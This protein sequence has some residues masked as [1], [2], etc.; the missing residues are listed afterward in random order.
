MKAHEIIRELRRPPTTAAVRW[1]LQTGGGTKDS[2]AAGQVVTY[3]D[4]RYVAER[5]NLVL[6]LGWTD[7]YE[8]LRNPQGEIVGCE[9]TITLTD[10]GGTLLAQ[11][12]DVG[13]FA[14]GNPGMYLKGLYSDAFK[15]CGVKLGIGSILY[16]VPLSWVDGA[17]GDIVYSKKT[18]K[19]V[20]FSPAGRQRL[21]AVYAKH[22]ASSAVIFGEPLDHGDA[23]NA[24]GD[25]E[26][27]DAPLEEAA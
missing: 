22:V 18:G 15:R 10:E 7:S 25:V 4:S 17:K 13:Y 21:D 3:I 5:L 27:G 6:G 23:M 11:R 20:T 8:L 24:Q 9:C 19:P 16:T 14:P 1:K 12:R 2:P 26:V